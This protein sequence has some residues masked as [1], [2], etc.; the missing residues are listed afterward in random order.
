M[1]KESLGKKKWKQK[2]RKKWKKM[3]F[4]EFGTDIS[5]KYSKFLL[6]KINIFF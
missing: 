6:F 5:K 1:K 3:I 2:E 4:S